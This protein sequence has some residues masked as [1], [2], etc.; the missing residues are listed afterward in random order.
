MDGTRVLCTVRMCVDDVRLA[1]GA[2]W[3]GDSG[4]TTILVAV[5]PRPI[6]QS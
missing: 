2:L 3:S 4:T 1:P 5:S 6:E